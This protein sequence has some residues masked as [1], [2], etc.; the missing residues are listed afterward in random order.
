MKKENFINLL[1]GTV[2]GMF[3][4]LGMCMCLLPEWNA[5][6]AGVVFCIIGII[7]LIGLLIFRMRLHKKPMK[8]LSPR[9]IG[10]AA[11]GTVGVLLLGL[12]MSMVMVWEGL[13]IWGIIVGM[14]G[15]ITLICL[16]PIWKGLN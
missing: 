5:F 1:L 7:T 4:A 11:M 8:K 9:T 14:A 16:I 2:G 15:I 12:G 10:I 13:L 3:F 6:T